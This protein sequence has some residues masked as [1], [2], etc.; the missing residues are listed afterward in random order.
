MSLLTTDL[1]SWVIVKIKEVADQS[2]KRL[3]LCSSCLQARYAMIKIGRAATL[4]MEE[5]LSK[6][7]QVYVSFSRANRTL[8]S[9]KSPH[10]HSCPKPCSSD[11]GLRTLGLVSS[12]VTAFS[13]SLGSS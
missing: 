4:N 9:G 10:I 13:L 3:V 2:Q 8:P 11:S 7:G 6:F 12:S 1:P 5:E